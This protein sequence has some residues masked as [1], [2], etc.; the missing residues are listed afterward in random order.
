MKWVKWLLEE[1]VILV[2]VL[3]VLWEVEMDREAKFAVKLWLIAV[4]LIG[5]LKMLQGG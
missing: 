2:V 1:I 3:I 4:F 5:V